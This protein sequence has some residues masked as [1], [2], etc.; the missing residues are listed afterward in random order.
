MQLMT[1]LRT[2]ADPLG[3][4]WAGALEPLETAA[5][6]N[7]KRWLESLL[8]PVRSG[9][10][11]QTAF[12]FGLFLDWAR[13]SGDALMRERVVEKTLAFHGNEMDAPIGHEPSGEDFLS[14]SLMTADLMTRLL[15]G[16]AFA[17]WLTAFLPGLPTDGNADWLPVAL[18]ADETDG[19]LVHLHGLNLSRAWNLERVANALPE[20][21][22]RMAALRSAAGLHEAAGLQALTSDYY[23]SSHWIA[24][25]AFYLMSV[26]EEG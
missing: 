22:S 20:R 14:P 25:F 17:D 15:E 6:R 21:D 13:V 19:R 12:A 7:I 5:A 2:W 26:R 24:T 4:E 23:V 3:R 9:T 18:V 8:Y 16:E 1:E 10:H 11:S